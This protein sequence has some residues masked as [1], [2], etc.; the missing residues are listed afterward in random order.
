MKGIC[1]KK[2]NLK[3]KAWTKLPSGGDKRRATQ[4]LVIDTEVVQGDKVIVTYK[5]VDFE[6]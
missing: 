2:R 5:A 3:K 4:Y 1:W 6:G